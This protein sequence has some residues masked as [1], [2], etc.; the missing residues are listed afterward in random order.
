MAIQQQ[1]VVEDP[2]LADELA[3]LAGGAEESLL[4]EGERAELLAAGRE[5]VLANFSPQARAIL[6]AVRP[7]EAHLAQE[8]AVEGALA[9]LQSRAE[10]IEAARAES[11]AE[12][13]ARELAG[14]RQSQTAAEA[15]AWAAR[16]ANQRVGV[17]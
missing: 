10:Q 8:A 9:D 6:E 3:A 2:E 16:Q 1:V 14:R 4:V 13:Q 15:A 17:Q 11:A 5:D 7:G 12:R